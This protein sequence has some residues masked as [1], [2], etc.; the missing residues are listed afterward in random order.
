MS[1]YNTTKVF[2]ETA[3]TLFSY[4]DIVRVCSLSQWTTLTGNINWALNWPGTK[5]SLD[6]G[7]PDLN[8]S[9]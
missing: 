5:A 2:S 4:Y 6:Q 9:K 3:Q 7:N 1:L 8:M